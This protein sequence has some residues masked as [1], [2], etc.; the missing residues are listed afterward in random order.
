MPQATGGL[1]A[2]KM[3][4]VT[5]MGW[6]LGILPRT[7]RL[8][9]IFPDSG[10]YLGKQGYQIMIQTEFSTSPAEWNL[11]HNL[12]KIRKWAFLAQQT[13][14]TESHTPYKSKHLKFFSQFFS[15]TSDKLIFLIIAWVMSFSG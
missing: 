12:K 10:T 13:Q 14:V 8:L 4:V 1:P 6:K 7:P 11:K 2:S 5:T 9:V 15:S 3:S